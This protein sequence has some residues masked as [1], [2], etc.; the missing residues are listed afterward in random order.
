MD[1]L[2]EKQL[3]QYLPYRLFFGVYDVNVRTMQKE[4]LFSGIASTK[5]TIHNINN[6]LDRHSNCKPI[7]KPLRPLIEALKYHDHSNNDVKTMRIPT[8]DIHYLCNFNFSQISHG[9]FV[10]LLRNH[11]ELG[12]W[13]DKGLAYNIN[14]FNQLIDMTQNKTVCQSCG[15]TFRDIDG[16]R[17]VKV[18][19][20]VICEDCKEKFDDNIEPE[21][22]WVND[23]IKIESSILNT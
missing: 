10:N 3:L 8:N 19:N 11:Y 2:G 1:K 21:V 23:A 6:Y 12:D 17:P 15:I 22:N 5:G 20:V 13:I 18:E 16:D 14:N 7:F 9:T 4:Y